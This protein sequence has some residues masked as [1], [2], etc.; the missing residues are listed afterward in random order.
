MNKLFRI[1]PLVLLTSGCGMAPVG[2][3]Y[4]KPNVEIPLALPIP[5][6]A[7]SAVYMGDGISYWQAFKDPTLDA[8]MREA[9]SNSQDLML[10][11]ARI[12]E[13]L[14][15]LNLLSASLLPTV[16]ANVGAT[17]RGLSQ[18]S[19]TFN[20]A[21]K[22]YSN[23]R[24][25]GL[26]ASYEIEFWGRLSRANEGARARLLAQEAS[27]GVV[28]TTLYAN[29]AQT[30]FLMRSLDAQ[31]R[32]AEQVLVTRQENLSLQEKRF[33]GGLTSQLDLSQAQSEAAAIQLSL[34]Q[35]KQAAANAHALLTLLLGRSPAA[36]LK[37]VIVRG[38]DA[39]STISA[40]YSAQ[41]VPA[42][43]PSDVLV[44]RPDIVS[45]EQLL[46]AANADIGLARAA[47]FPRLSLTAA[48][49]QQSKELSSLFNAS[50]LFWNFA[51]N[52]TAPI[53]RA[54]AIDAQVAA[55]QARQKQALAQYT[56]TVQAAFRDVHDALNNI[57]AGRDLVL[58]ST[59]RIDALKTTLHLAQV[60]YKG[61]YS[62]YLEVLN[63][64][65]DLTQA[66]SGL[67]DF[68]RAQ[69]ASVVS[70]YKAL[71]GGWAAPKP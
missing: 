49:G 55:S 41:A 54:G 57:D 68:Q 4:I 60:R 31:Q 11:S 14:A 26:S 18:N 56:Q 21:I 70:L 19:S 37:P 27:R 39:E 3:N 53:F 10:A 52:L 44:R 13:A 38:S 65:R 33:K 25:V 29:V 23:D 32:L 48:V 71:G 61:G 6:A 42:N 30:Y 67:I 62:N 34:I 58:A 69:L 43:L 24:Q 63:A 50:S 16:D 64:Q 17:R 15:G 9:A 28:L 36:I 1:W 12:E 8:L 2:P 66:Q 51:G 40:L 59:A 45:S 46:M 7:N 47:Y 35:A 22:P 20:P 5:I